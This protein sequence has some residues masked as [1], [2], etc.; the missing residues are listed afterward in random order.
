LRKN[1]TRTSYYSAQEIFLRKYNDTELEKNLNKSTATI[2][3][4]MIS[5][6]FSGK[7]CNEK[8]FDGISIGEFH[9]CYQF[10]TNDDNNRAAIKNITGR[11]GKQGGLQLEL[12]IGD[13]E[14]CRSPLTITSG[15]NFNCCFF[16]A[17]NYVNL[18]IC[19]LND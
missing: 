10:N 7:R 18:I 8:D 14:N 12:F 4:M 9:R 19:L 11:D 13:D 6:Q 17:F 2:A 15:Y 16:V 5:C 1:Q 3:S